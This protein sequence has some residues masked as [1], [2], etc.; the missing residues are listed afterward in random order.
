MGL[1]RLRLGSK[2]Q[3]EQREAALSSWVHICPLL[4]RSGHRIP[5]DHRQLVADC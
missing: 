2:A 4:V 3:L 1:L 5:A